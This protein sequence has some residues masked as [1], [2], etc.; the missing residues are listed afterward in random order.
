VFAKEGYVNWKKTI[1]T[2]RKHGSCKIHTDARLK[3]DDFMN[4]RKNVVRQ[5]NENTKEKD[6]R[7]EIRLTS[8]LDVVR[9]LTMQGDAFRG[10]DESSTSLNKG[11]FK[12]LVD[13]YKGKVEIVK[14]AYERQLVG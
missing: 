2:F 4:Q 9:F 14:D 10:H 6:K 7:Y 1:E 8:S 12:E 13:W 5:Y 11:T 3:C